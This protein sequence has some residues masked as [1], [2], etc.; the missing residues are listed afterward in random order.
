[1]SRKPYLTDLVIRNITPPA[2]GPNTD[3]PDGKLPGF[4]V[5]VSKTGR[6]TFFF[7]Y[8]F[9][10]DRYRL[11][12]GLYPDVS[13]ADARAKAE[14]AR[15]LLRKGINPN[16]QLGDNPV[17]AQPEPS[18]ETQGDPAP[19]FSEAV[20]LY[21]A[22]YLKVECAANTAKEKARNI[23]STF[24][25]HFGNMAIDTITYKDIDK[26]LKAIVTSGRKSAAIHAHADLRHFFNWHVLKHHI[27]ENPLAGTPRPAK[28]NRRKR[29]LKGL[30]IKAIWEAAEQ[31]PYPL[32][33]LSQIALLTAQRRSEIAQMRW[34]EIHF[35]NGI[36]TIPGT[37]TKNG[38]D[39]IVPLSNLAIE[40]LSKIRPVPLKRRHGK[41]RVVFSPFVFPR[42]KNPEEPMKWFSDA[43]AR[44]EKRAQVED[45]CLHDMRRT[46]TTGFG[47]FRIDLKARKKILNHAENTVTDIYD[48]FEYF[49]QR[50]EALHLWAE[51]V[52]KA[53]AGQIN[54]TA[55][56]YKNPFVTAFAQPAAANTATRSK[57]A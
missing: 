4:G 32:G 34:D 29:T 53:V 16:T 38:H 1:M 50:C 55:T 13:L 2:K 23:R 28:P 43:K 40:V 41:A 35:E 37:R 11:N 51:Y 5:R 52:R 19:G 22:F 3:V 15:V 10:G 18:A 46:A 45:W 21:E 54:S 9:A 24:K 44:L 26:I 49:E 20:D 48:R 6:K 7:A 31:D 14:E 39:H 17:P 57:A 27:K 12:L 8:R 47:D 33:Y 25:P 30:E 56:V 42:P 36:W